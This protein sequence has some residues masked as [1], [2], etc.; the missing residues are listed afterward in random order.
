M[1]ERGSTA[2]PATRRRPLL[3]PTPRRQ[4]L[5]EL[6]AAIEAR[7]RQALDDEIV[8]PLQREWERNRRGEHAGAARGPSGLVAHYELDGSFSDISGRYQHGRTVVG[9][10]T[11][12]VGQIGRAA[13]STATP[14]SASATSAL[15]PAARPFSLAVWIRG[16]GNLPMAVAEARRRR[17]RGYESGSTTGA[18][19]HP[20]LGGAPDDDAGSDAPSGNASGCAR[21]SGSARRLVSRRD[22]LRRLGQGRRPAALSSTAS[23]SRSRSCADAWPDRSSTRRARHR[24]QRVRAK[25]F[26]GQI[27]DLRFLQP[28]ADAGDEIERLAVHYPVARDPVGRDGKRSKDEAADLR[29]TYFLTYAAPEPAAHGARRA[30]GAADQTHRAREDD[31][32]RD[33]DDRDAEA[34]RDLRARARRLSQ[35][36]PR[37]CSPACRRCCRRSP[38]GAPLNRLT[39]AKWLVEPDHPLTARVAVNR[40]WQ[41]YFGVGLVK[42]QEDFGV[43][44]EPPVHPEL[45]DWLAT[46][47][48]RTGWDVKAMQRLI[49]TSA[50]YRQSSACHA[51]AARADPENRLLARGPRFRLPAEMIR[52]TAL[53][54]SG[55]LNGEIGGPSVKPYQPAGALGGDGFGDGFSAQPYEQSHGK[56]LYRRGM[57]TFWKRT[58][59]PA[60]LRRSTPDREKCTARRA[61][62]NTPLQALVL[63]NDPTYVEAA[64][65]LAQRMLPRAGD[66]DEAP[67]AWRSGWAHGAQAGRQGG[68]RAARAAA[69][70]ARA[71]ARDRQAAREAAVASANRRATSVLD[72]PSWRR[73]RSWRARS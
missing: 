23:G 28:G 17:R 66:D 5:D 72:P 36:G 46:E 32:D 67:I 12:D 52:D 20:A 34:A 31:S 43:Q 8:A 22:D 6:D 3:L 19:R 42:T 49:V 48:V 29:A 33:G 70:R 24:R 38:K 63:L 4:R 45:L 68:P 53:A 64:R 26:V 57:Y 73:G 11:F 9:D 61:L 15:R 59:P 56:D 50:T 18:V 27:D 39:L 1:P 62:T 14:R 55:L 51:G 21:A 2:A 71:F 30:E 47:F 41:M 69:A 25:P 16:R 10:P 13:P 44:G 35:Q 60:S 54:V 7:A 40:F 58:V 37:R 65:A